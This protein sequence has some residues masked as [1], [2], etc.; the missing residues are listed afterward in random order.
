VTISER[1]FVPVPPV[2][3]IVQY[4]G[5]NAQECIDWLN[6]FPKGTTGWGGKEW[7][8]QRTDPN[9][10]LFISMASSEF[11]D[12]C[13]FPWFVNWVCTRLDDQ[14]FGLPIAL[15]DATV[16]WTEVVE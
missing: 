2:M 16:G 3:H 13:A 1:K 10:D 8:I 14:S 9:G 12:G 11:G 6:T 15:S 7:H 4:T 5:S